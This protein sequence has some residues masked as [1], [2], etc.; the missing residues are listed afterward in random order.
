M[1]CEKCGV[2]VDDDATK[3]FNCG[4]ELKTKSP[5]EKLKEINHTISISKEEVEE[6]NS[7]T[8]NDNDVIYGEVVNQKPIE[9]KNNENEKTKKNKTKNNDTGKNKAKSVK[10]NKKTNKTYIRNICIC[11]TVILIALIAVDFFIKGSNNS[12]TIVLENGAYVEKN[13][14]NPVI[15]FESL[16]VLYNV[17]TEKNSVNVIADS[18]DEIDTGLVKTFDK[19]TFFY[20]PRNQKVTNNG[21]LEFTLFKSSDDGE[22]IVEIPSLEETY[23]VSE[24]GEKIIY[25]DNTS[26]LYGDDVGEMYYYN[27]ESKSRTFIDKDVVLSSVFIDESSKNAVYITKDD[28][29]INTYAFKSEKSKQIDEKVEEIFYVSGDL[30][31]IVYTKASRS[32]GD[33]KVCSLHKIQDKKTIIDLT[34][35]VLEDSIIL[36][37][38]AIIYLKYPKTYPDFGKYNQ[39]FK[40]NKPEDAKKN[41]ELFDKLCLDN[42]FDLAKIS[43]NNNEEVEVANNIVA[44]NYVTDNGERIIFTKL[45]DIENM[46]SDSI[47]SID[48]IISAQNTVVYVSN[49]DNKILE[50][51]LFYDNMLL[52]DDGTKNYF[53]YNEKT[54]NL[55]FID[56]DNVLYAPLSMG[57]E[58]NKILSKQL[59]TTAI[60]L[61]VYNNEVLV[62]SK[63]NE[64]KIIDKKLNEKIIDSNVIKETIYHDENSI[65]YQ[66]K[67]EN[68]KNELYTVKN[69][70]AE[71]I[72]DSLSSKDILVFGE[73]MYYEDDNEGFSVFNRNKTNLVDKNATNIKVVY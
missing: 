22:Q 51:E 73:N 11:V 2:N 17:N 59:N 45:K 69:N 38:D 54:D 27:N 3:C 48:D 20:Y 23:Y 49:N 46:N 60:Y 6:I 1:K 13:M 56:G 58:Q 71:L 57:N 65:F 68:N 34:D 40:D 42:L 7:K 50:L 31:E 10:P 41:K 52:K 61:S 28:M 44:L 24:D 19:N 26:N 8:S 62:L 30:S 43:I 9:S 36:K 47:K 53:A 72:T 4:A 70:K 18:I 35:D 25:F 67:G 16:G 32:V 21:V 5:M 37:N 66:K 63:E 14:K 29:A 55:Y 15:V 39:Y 12:K 64:L 33:N